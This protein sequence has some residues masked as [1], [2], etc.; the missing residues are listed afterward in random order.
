MNGYPVDRVR[1]VLDAIQDGLRLYPGVMDVTTSRV[2]LIAGDASMSDFRLQGVAYGPDDDDSAYYNYVGPEY[3]R[4]LGIPL[5]AGREFLPGDSEGT[6]KVAIVNEAFLQRNKLG[7]DAIGKRL[8]RMGRSSGFD[9][10]IIGVASNSAYDDV[11]KDTQAP[12]V[13]MPS[14]QDPDLAGANFYV[15]TAGSEQDILAALPR[16][17]QAIDPA[18]PVANPR[19]M[20][21]QVV[22]NVALDRFVTTMSAAFASLATLL[23]AL[24]LYGVLAYTVSQRTKEFGLRMALGAD[25]GVVRRL[26]LRQVC[27]MTAAGAA[28]GVASALVLGF[29]AESLLFQMNARDPFVISAALVF[30]TLVA[31]CAGLIPAHRAG[32]VDPMTALRYE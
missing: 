29:A 24:G 21:A 13:L 28:I 18:L 8:Q 25:S 15:R 2:R 7:R 11:K 9:I 19:T 31:L 6:L 4:T 30:L 22:E 5:V 12:L 32:R 27:L 10:E 20:T 14:R 23:A 1:Q 17:V 26:V 3:L 16:I